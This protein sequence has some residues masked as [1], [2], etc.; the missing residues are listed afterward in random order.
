MGELRVLDGGADRS[1]RAEVAEIRTAATALIQRLQYAR[2][3]GISLGG[4][5][6]LRDLQEILG[7]E[8]I[9]TPEMYRRR[10]NRGGIA[11]RCVD[12]LPKATWR[13][14]GELIEDDNPRV[15]TAFEKA[16]ATLDIR[17]KVWANLQR[18]DIL[19]GLGRYAVLLL[20][21]PG[22]LDTPLPKG[23]AERLVYLTPFSE[24]DAK[25]LEWDTDIHSPRF[26]MPLSY[27]LTKMAANSALV[28]NY[29][30][31]APVFMSSA[32]TKPV[33][34]TRVIHIAE[35]ILDNEVFGRPTLERVWNLLND[36]DKVTGGGAEAFWLRA[37]QGMQLDIDKDMNLS[38]E[39]KKNLQDQAD[40]YQHQ[41]RR[42]LRTRGVDVKMLGSDTANFANPAD[43]VIT[44]IAGALGIPKR[45]LTGS[46]MGELASSQ[47]RENWRD[48][49]NGRQ[50]GYAAPY[51][52]RPFADRLIE[53]G[54]LPP[55]KDGPS[56]YTVRWPHTQILTEQERATG[57]Q[58]WTNANATQ[59][60]AVFT[61][62]EIRDHWYGWAPLTKKQIATEQENKQLGAPEPPPGAPGLPGA[63]A[64]GGP[65]NAQPKGLPGNPDAAPRLPTTD[66]PKADAKA[67]TEKADENKPTAR[68]KAAAAAG[69][70]LT[71]DEEAMV[72][73]LETALREGDQAALHRIIGW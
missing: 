14:G 49:V 8:D 46:E 60:S 27:Q 55:P 35:G 30:S 4:F 58:Q 57:V 43:S 45:I 15:Y 42:M 64:P 36:L 19:A 26:G 48:Q 71:A 32:L 9:I 23:K 17:L 44:Q 51:I 59:G 56:E 2:A 69:E 54:Y 67:T 31:Y 12:A 41:I 25:I 61:G 6:G 29:V 70:D 37:N 38:A 5:G 16:W 21:A 72:V 34:W 28:T 50:S 7:Y 1:E 13:G 39:E 10:Y 20:G 62:D 3:A 66:A 24:E 11:G 68:P 47:D 33:H 73:A 18:V 22:E 63:A 40:E 53:Y 65:G 52:I